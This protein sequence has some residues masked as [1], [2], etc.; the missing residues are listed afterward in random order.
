MMHVVAYVGRQSLAIA[1]HLI[2]LCAFNYCI[3]AQFGKR[4]KHG[5]LLI[6]KTSVEQL[7]FTGVQILP[8]VIPVALLTGSFLILQFL[9]VSGQYD[10]GK[11]SVF[12]LVRELGP[13]ITAFLIILRSATAV[14]VEISYMKVLHEIEA[15]EMQ[16]IPVYRIICLPRLI[17]ISAAMLGLFFIF[18]V[19]AIMGGSA[20]VWTFTELPVTTFLSQIGRAIGP[21]D[22]SVGILKAFL[23]GIVITVTCLYH[24]LQSRKQI[25]S[26]PVAA[27][28]ASVE[29]FFYC[30]GFNFFVS[31][32]FYV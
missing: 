16:G 19:V 22:I 20:I 23:F 18:D 27:S 8:I 3:L 11:T 31:L 7:Y 1:N 32:F 15:I 12:L 17:G 5:R 26:V 2:N 21:S 28:R 10:F 6:W 4:S 25:T 14:T 30:I 9:K 24:G 13:M 29:S